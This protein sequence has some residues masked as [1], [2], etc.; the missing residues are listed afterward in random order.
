VDAKKHPS[1]PSCQICQQDAQKE[2]VDGKTTLSA[3]E[4]I[5]SQPEEIT[6]FP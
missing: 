6:L 2:K 5:P 4:D 3:S 1:G